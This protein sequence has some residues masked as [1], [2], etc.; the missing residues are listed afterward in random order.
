M[1]SDQL[2]NSKINEQPSI[3]L[4]S[5]EYLS[6]YRAEPEPDKNYNLKIN[7]IVYPV[8]QKKRTYKEA[9]PKVNNLKMLTDEKRSGLGLAGQNILC[10][11]SITN[12]QYSDASCKNKSFKPRKQKEN[13]ISRYNKSNKVRTE[14]NSLPS[15]DPSSE[16][17]SSIDHNTDK[18]SFSGFTHRGNHKMERPNLKDHIFDRMT[19]QDLMANSQQIEQIEDSHRPSKDL[20]S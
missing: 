12:S 11:L 19:Q 7:T 17:E 15:A 6:S 4:D 10:S 18:E 14:Q 2:Y 16:R 1:A 8:D 13:N 9:A 20:N 3:N 5:N